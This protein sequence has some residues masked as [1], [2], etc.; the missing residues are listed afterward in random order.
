MWPISTNVRRP[1]RRI[2][3]NDPEKN[4]A[5][6]PRPSSE[7]VYTHTRNNHRARRRY[8]DYIGRFITIASPPGTRLVRNS[9][10][11]PVRQTKL[12]IISRRLSAVQPVRPARSTYTRRSR[13]N[14]PRGLRAARDGSFTRACS[15]NVFRHVNPFAPDKPKTARFSENDFPRFFF[16]FRT[17]SARARPLITIIGRSRN[18][19]SFE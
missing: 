16:V 4:S 19:R 15:I 5:H 17:R 8:Y 18:G 12:I 3:K 14:T 9:I 13:R 6:A 7:C 1:F 11:T 2:I 10:R